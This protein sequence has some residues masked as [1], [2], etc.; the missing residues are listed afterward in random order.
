MAC[1]AQPGKCVFV[2]DDMKLVPSG[3]FWMGCNIALDTSCQL[4][5]YPYHEVHV[6]GFL[7]DRTEVTV[8]AYGACVEAAGCTEPA[9]WPG[10]CNWSNVAAALLPVNCVDWQ[11]AVDYCQ[12]V[13]KRLCKEAEWERA[14]R[15][16]LG[17]IFPWGNGSASCDLAVMFRHGL[18]GC[19][20]GMTWEVGS[21]PQGASPSGILDLSGNVWEWTA[22]WYGGAYYSSSSA[23]NPPGPASGI[24][25]VRRGGGYLD[26]AA[27]LRCSQRGYSDPLARNTDLGIRCC[28]S[29]AE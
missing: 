5:E 19:G 8:D 14:A 9:T 16:S 2:P 7:I 12:W 4:N 25:R 27:Y 6:D 20:T 29:L 17:A 1:D 10:A 28:K 26:W 23:S 21:K 13:G 24:Y 18:P 11:Q 3:P 22:D 15:G